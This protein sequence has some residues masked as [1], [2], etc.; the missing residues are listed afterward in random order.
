M[1]S[2]TQSAAGTPAFSERLPLRGASWSPAR[3]SSKKR[4]SGTTRPGPEKVAES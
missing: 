3:L 2:S 1:R 4:A